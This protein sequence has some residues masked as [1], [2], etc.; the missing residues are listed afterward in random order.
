MSQE[1]KDLEIKADEL[2]KELCDDEIEAATGGGDCFCL[3]GGYGKR[4]SD[5][6][7]Y[8]RVRTC[9]CVV[10]GLNVTEKDNWVRCLCLLTGNGL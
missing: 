7:K 9:V 3:V 4:S 8:N 1:Q 2:G 10:F 6:K 5:E